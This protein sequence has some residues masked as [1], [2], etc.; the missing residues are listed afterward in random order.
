LTIKLFIASLFILFIP[1]E[2]FSQYPHYFIYNNDNGMPTNEIYSIIQDEKGFIWIGSDA[3][4][5]KFNGVRYISYKSPKQKSRTIA[6]LTK[7]Y[8]TKKLYCT[9]FQ[10]QLFYIENDSLIE[11]PH[12]YKSVSNIECDKIGNVYI[13][14]QDG[15]SVFNEQTKR[16]KD[17]ND[18]GAK[19]THFH[20]DFTKSARS[21]KSNEISFLS[22][23]GI[24]LL[25]GNNLQFIRT[26][27]DSLL[28]SDFHITWHNNEKWIFGITNTIVAKIENK[29]VK[30]IT[31]EKLSSLLKGRKITNVLSL[32]DN[33]L[34]IC[35]YSGLIR[36]NNET[37][38]VE[39]L[40]P[41][42]SF[43]NCL[44]DREK[45]YWFSTLQTGVLCVP[46]L[47][48]T[49]W[50][51]ENNLLKID[52]LTH[53]STDKK[54]IFF[55]TSNGTIGQLNVIDKKLTTYNTEHNADVQSLNY[56]FIDQALYFNLNNH[57]Y[58][59]KNNKLGEKKSVI[60]SIKS[61]KHIDSL[62]CIA[63][64]F[65]TFIQNGF[66]FESKKMSPNWTREFEYDSI[67][68]IIWVATN[69]GLFQIE[70]LLNKWVITRSILPEKQILSLT[71]E[72]K[73]QIL[74]VL[75][76]NGDVYAIT[77]NGKYSKV[78][79]QPKNTHFNKLT[80]FNNQLIIAS[81]S[82]IWIYSLNT[83]KWRHLNDLFGLASNIVHD[84]E[85]VNNNLWLATSKGL[86][87]IPLSE[88]EEKPLAFISLKNKS[89]DTEN[90]RLNHL[91]TLTLFPEV[92]NYASHGNYNYN[93]RIN[94]GNWITLPATIEKIELQNIPSGNFTVELKAIDYLNRDSAN[95]LYLSGYVS[96]PF[97][98]TWWFKLFELLF[99]STLA[100]LIGKKII[101]TIRK[102]E[103]EKTAFI[104]SEL[105]ALKAQMNPHF[106]YNA[107]NSIQALILKKD[108]INSNLYLGQFSRLMRT[109]LET[110]GKEQ[111][112]LQEEI[113]TLQLYLSLEQLR[114]GTDFKYDISIKDEID[115]YQYYLPP[116][117]LQPFVENSIKHGLLHKKGD[118]QLQISF[119]LEKSIL[120][121]QII[122]NGI[123]RKHAQEIK[124]RQYKAPSSF[125]TNATKKRIELFNSIKGENIQ[126]EIKDVYQNDH[127]AGTLV[128][129][130]IP[131]SYNSEN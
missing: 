38:E 47:N 101:S 20:K 10:S 60:S 88:I 77:K 51:K 80:Y 13:N 68:K 105:T 4:L 117:L 45:N 91:Q 123:G 21:N 102:R 112:S 25:Q 67:N 75:T 95:I 69:N 100:F 39:L 22:S 94:Q 26:P 40:Y 35:T 14:H 121:C 28:I 114:F 12:T 74:Y 109:I 126:I 99:I 85:V 54:H 61:I 42:Y 41:E 116:L 79:K 11:L 43:S 104:H 19:N 24:G 8:L 70:S 50:N 108:I 86:Q 103:K 52:K 9:N 33:Q 122:D 124:D 82:G 6:G 15:I 36:Y 2:Y 48:Y 97:W 57:L 55:S 106:M 72:S 37:G 31:N 107:L 71:F 128:K 46:N 58:Y 32:E 5:F 56:D 3:G 113:E 44:I 29:I 127:P 96:P 93:Y 83:K 63:S 89:F 23:A 78:E 130:T 119:Q 110:S 66:D 129:L 7:S 118:K 18:F 16:W 87:K 92:S 125:S 115:T 111:I 84:L 1:I 30:R 65:G 64:S 81:N 59:I 62:Y 90:I 131:N 27:F 120:V 34:W 49:V 98:Q 73:K 17:F 76:F 53:L